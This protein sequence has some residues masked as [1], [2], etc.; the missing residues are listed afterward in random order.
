MSYTGDL[1]FAYIFEVEHEYISNTS[2]YFS[3]SKEMISPKSFDKMSQ[4][5][6]LKSPLYSPSVAF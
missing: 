4:I 2:T 1:F 6:R 5:S 3:F